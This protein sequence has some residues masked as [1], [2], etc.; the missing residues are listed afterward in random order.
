MDKFNQYIKSLHTILG[1]N[2]R[3][4]L[5]ID[6]KNTSLLN[7][8]LKVKNIL[9]KN[10][11]N[12]TD[13]L[14]CINNKNDFENFD[15]TLIPKSFV[16]KP[17]K[18]LGGEGIIIA[19]GKKKKKN[20]FIEDA[21]VMP[22]NEVIYLSE[23]KTHIINILDGNFSI[24]KNKDI[25][26]FEKRINGINLFTKFSKTGI[27][28][29][30]VIIFKKI[31]IMAEIRIPTIESKGK[32]NL[33]SGGIGVGIDIATGVTTN[34]IL[35]NANIEEHP[36][37]HIRLQ[38][39]KIPHWNSILKTSIEAVIALGV[40]FTGVDISIDR[41]NGVLVLEVNARP[42]L[43]IQIANKAGMRE[44][45]NAIAKLKI[46]NME[47]AIRIAKDIF[48]GEIEEE[49]QEITG[50]IVIGRKVKIKINNYNKLFDAKVDTGAYRT[51]I[52]EDIA[53]T[54][55]F[56]DLINKF[57]SLNIPKQIDINNAQKI[58]DNINKNNKEL[59]VIDIKSANGISIR[60]IINIIIEI[61]NTNINLNTEATIADRADMSYPTIIGRKDLKKFLIDITK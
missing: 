47:S 24:D 31:P 33:H 52:S 32:A 36:D 48:G 45:L 2:S 49:I 35:N 37:S 1:M 46:K 20:E 28:D 11:I 58:R 10:N 56:T 44:R 8:K 15:F 7:S 26:I 9:Q 17:N 55:G 57:Y 38:G 27:S 61:Y 6:K 40:E 4:L 54:I 13:T 41:D 14:F 23:L 19:Y 12:T 50:K 22:N 3:N 53:K 5:F 34:A 39:I 30:R 29:I 60:P 18:G 16:L 25:A 59:Q 21:W 43:S 51:S 42:G